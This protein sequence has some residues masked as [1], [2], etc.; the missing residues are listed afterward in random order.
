M[1]LGKHKLIGGIDNPIGIHQACDLSLPL[2]P[3]DM[4]YSKCIKCGAEFYLGG[5]DT[6]CDGKWHDDP[7][8]WT[9]L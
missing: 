4:D 3:V 5:Q 7:Y 1:K 9:R 2:L 6:P 8:Y